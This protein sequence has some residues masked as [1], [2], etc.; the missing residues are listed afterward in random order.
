[1]LKQYEKWLSSPAVDEKTKEE[2]LS[3][4]GDENE[5]AAR[6]SAPMA[7][8]TAGL[9]SI[10]RAGISSMNVYTVA[11]TT[12][13]LAQ[14]ILKE[15]GA[16]RGVAIA[17]D[18]RLNSAL[19][20]RTA[21]EVLAYNGIKVYFFET[22]RPTP[23]LSFAILHHNCIAGINITAS[24][25]PK[26]YNGY[27]VYWED[28]A[29]LP[30]DHA[31]SVSEATAAIDIFSVQRMPF[32]EGVDSGI[33]EIIGKDTDNAFLDAVLACCIN[34]E[35][36]KEH[37]DSL[38][39]IYTSLHG[40]GI[41]LIPEAMKRCGI[42]N[43]RVVPSQKNP[44][45]NFP[46][47]KSPNPETPECFADAFALDKEA[48]CDSMLVIAT[49]PDADRT[50]A[51]IRCK[52]GTFM[53]L[54]GNQIGALL[55]DYI[56]KGRREQNKL[57]TNACAIKSLVSSPLFDAICKDAGV[58]P[59]NVLTGFKYIGEKIK[60]FEATKEHTFIFGYE[61]SFGFLA[62]S[63]ARDKD[64]VS[65]SVLIAEM[66][67]YYKS[68]GKTLYEVL[69]ELYEKFGYYRELTVGIDIKGINP[70]E[71]MKQT[72][73][74]LRTTPPA[75]LAGTKVARMRD[76][77]SNTVFENSVPTTPEAKL[78]SADML[79]FELANGTDVVIRPS[80]TEP[81]IKLYVLANDKVS[82]NAEKKCRIYSDAMKAILVPEK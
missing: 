42:T 33:I 43:L 63:Y 29:Q 68:K 46:T 78:P 38:N 35:A 34:T 73:A 49:D 53:T 16:S 14:L 20:A 5:I 55:V 70:M 51:S 52:D 59:M 37:G 75:E 3:V 82:E 4:K 64:A 61:E 25:N 76:Y 58:T 54:T 39:I 79:Y 10:M 41:M 23:E 8:G 12:A 19:F 13:G 67:A 72:M 77:K 9:R 69:C 26:E 30:P 32:Q 6:F 18:S 71:Q 47:V 57:P 48:D 15:G 62:G 22:L 11:Q 50:G 1:M 65:A 28:G 66:A 17:C 7:F 31:T 80:G 56:I 40:T 60:E 45:G 27:K 74:S 44:D 24:H 2:L 36:M 81:K 21:A